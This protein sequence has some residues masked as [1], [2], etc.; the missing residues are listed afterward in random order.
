ML[1]R[2]SR[3]LRSGEVG[4]RHAAV[5]SP[6]RRAQRRLECEPDHIGARSSGLSQN[7]AAGLTIRAAGLGP[8][9]SSAMIRS[10]SIRFALFCA[11]IGLYVLAG[12]AI[13]DRQLTERV[14]QVAAAISVSR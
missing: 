1:P 4:S 8:E 11:A 5:V 9:E 7:K 2:H 14:V 3:T 10:L 6:S 12:I 13:A